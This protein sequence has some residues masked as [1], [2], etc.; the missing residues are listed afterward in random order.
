MATLEF[1]VFATAD[2]LTQVP[3]LLAAAIVFRRAW[4]G[5]EGQLVEATLP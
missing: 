2:F 3:I 4:A 1:A 5:H